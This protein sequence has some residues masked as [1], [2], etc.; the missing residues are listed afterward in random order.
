MHSFKFCEERFE[1]LGEGSSRRVYALDSEWVAKKPISVGGIWQNSNELSV[2]KKYQNTTLP[3][4]PIDLTRST[5][6]YIVMRR[7]TPINEIDDSVDSINDDFDSIVME[8]VDVCNLHYNT[9]TEKKK[10]IQS[11]VNSNTDSRI[12]DFIKRLARFKSE[13]INYLFTDVCS[14]NCGLLDN[15]VIVLDYGYP[16]TDE[17]L[18][19]N[20]YTPLPEYEKYC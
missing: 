2:Y 18:T 3:I 14:F 16:A 4:C 11:I 12:V 6:N 20:F 7:V 8:Y 15:K 13:T 9:P 10:F 5:N 17:H 19:A 1:I